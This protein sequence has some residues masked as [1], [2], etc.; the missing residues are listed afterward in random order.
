MKHCTLR[1]LTSLYAALLLLGPLP[2]VAED[3]T[4]TPNL[5]PAEIRMY[6]VL[7]DGIPE[8]APKFAVTGFLGAHGLSYSDNGKSPAT[9]VVTVKK[10]PENYLLNGT[11]HAFLYFDANEHLAGYI[12]KEDPPEKAATDNPSVSA[13]TPSTATVTAPAAATPPPASANIPA[14]DNP[15]VTQPAASSDNNAATTGVATPSTPPADYGGWASVPAS[16]YST[17]A[18]SAP[19]GQ[20]R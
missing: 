7:H 14:N 18:G 15:A 20:A 12:V 6:S 3:T 16:G 17:P 19:N 4:P 11:L 10:T 2:V 9:I 8:H 5:T 1:P 13:K